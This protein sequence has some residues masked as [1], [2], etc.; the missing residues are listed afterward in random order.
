MQ[1]MHAAPVYPPLGP[2]KQLETLQRVPLDSLGGGHHQNWVHICDQH[3]QKV[4]KHVLATLVVFLLFFVKILWQRQCWVGLLWL[5]IIRD[6][7]PDPWWAEDQDQAI[8]A[9]ILKDPEL[10][11][12][13]D[14]LDPRLR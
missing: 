6:H 13:A 1:K 9:Q 2:W 14:P 4:P 3:H 7:P 12:S 5:Q 10:S 11:G 8:L